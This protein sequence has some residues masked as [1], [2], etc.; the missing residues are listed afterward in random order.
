MTHAPLRVTTQP[1]FVSVTEVYSSTVSMVHLSS[2]YTL[3]VHSYHS[4]LFMDD[5]PF[6]PL[7]TKDK[8]QYLR[9]L[10]H[11]RKAIC[12]EQRQCQW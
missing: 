10:K 1:V 2:I 11:Q 7:W 12:A 4:L 3:L 8:L 9:R 5:M 6:T